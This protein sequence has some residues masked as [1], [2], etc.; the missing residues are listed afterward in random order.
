MKKFRKSSGTTEH[1]LRKP[2]R[3]VGT[4]IA[5]GATMFG[6]STYMIGGGV[7]HATSLDGTS[8]CVYTDSTSG[9]SSSLFGNAFVI[10]T[11]G[12]TLNINCSVLN[13]TATVIAEASPLAAYVPPAA[14]ITAALAESEPLSAITG[15]PVT[16][17]AL[18]TDITIPATFAAGN[19]G[20]G[21]NGDPN[22]SCPP[23]QAQVNAGLADCTLALATG[24]GSPLNSVELIYTNNPTPAAPTLNLTYHN[25]LAGDTL[26]V[27][28]GG[29]W[30][31]STPGTSAGP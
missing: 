30:P 10:V 8:N 27:S 2:I 14:P 26:N 4:F 7:A 19:A 28:G 5:A 15:V 21:V 6:L 11:A 22:A 29:W 31:G 18:N 9:V 3:T 24:A 13:T 25:G 17:N 1:R 16:G 20:L 12:D 23:T